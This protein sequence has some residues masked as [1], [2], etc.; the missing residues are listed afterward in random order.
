MS[1]SV[2]IVQLGWVHNGWNIPKFDKFDNIYAIKKAAVVLN[3]CLIGKIR[4]NFLV[5]RMIESA[6]KTFMHVQT[7]NLHRV[8]ALTEA[9]IKSYKTRQEDNKII[10]L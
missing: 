5:P 8:K 9:L 6:R 7:L 3:F 1:D 10:G 4:H 2:F